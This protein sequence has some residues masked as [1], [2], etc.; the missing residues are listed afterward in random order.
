MT[1][2][3]FYLPSSDG[4]SRLHGI[5]WLPDG[6]VKAV[7]QLSHGM[8]EHIGRYRE[9]GRYLAERGIAV[10]GHDHLG[11]GKTAESE[12]NLGYFGERGASVYLIKDIH[13]LTIY[14]RNRYPGKKL[15]LL[16]HSMGS[17]FTRRYLTV[18]PDGP[19]GVL[20]LGTGGQSLP[21]VVFGYLLSVIVAV[22]KGDTCRSPLLHRLSL[23]NYNRKFYPA[24]TGHDWLSRD[25]KQVGS[26]ENDRLC[27]FLFTAGAYRDFFRVIIELTIAE[28]AGKMRKDIP[29]LFLSGAKDPVGEYGKGVRRV[30]RRYARNGVKDLTL[31]FYQ[32]ARHELLNE[33]NREEVLTDIYFWITKYWYER[34]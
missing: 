18:Y 26:Y 3:E 4:K 24:N 17:F 27:S 14:G 19:D 31:G 9:T 15:F 34:Q 20:L 25:G 22:L 12:A 30:Y 16:G 23:G 5:E 13:R 7:L 21:L 10:Y 1:E 6:E 29:V 2:R 11:H 32:D 28:T 33:I 8:I